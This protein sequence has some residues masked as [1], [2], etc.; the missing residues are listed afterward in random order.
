MAVKEVRFNSIL[1]G[2]SPSQ[3]VM[4]DGQYL[5]SLGIDPDLPLSS[6]DIR[7]SGAVVPS[8]YTKFSG[9][10]VNASVVAILTN[11]KNTNTYVVL[12]NGRLISYDSSLGS[13]TLIGTVSGGL[14]CGAWVYNNFLYLTTGT[15]V[16]R[17]GP[18]DSSPSLVDSWWTSTLSLTATT[19]TTYPTVQ[20]VSVPNHWGCIHG[21]GSAY[22][23]DFKNGQGM[24]HRINTK[25]GTYEG[26]TNGTTVPSAYNVLDLPFGFYPV[27]ISSYS[28]DLAILCI[29]TTDTTVNQGKAALFLWDPTNTDTFYRGP[30]Y[31]PDPLGTAMLYANGQ[32]NIWSGNAQ[33]G[34]RVS[35]Y[36][37]G[38]VVS[39]IAF[40]EEGTPPLAGAVDA[41]GSRLVWGGFATSPTTAACVYALG[42]KSLALPAGL[43]NVAK[44]TSAGTTPLVSAVKFVQQ[45]S[46]ISPKFVIGWHDGSGSGLDSFATSGTCGSK[47]R[48][49][50]NV[51]Q[52]FTVKTLRIPLGAA[53]TTNMSIV[54]KLL[55]DD[56]STTVTLDTI[57]P[58]GTFN[59][60]RYA[61]YKIGAASY[62]GTNDLVVELNFGGTVPLPV[63]LPI[64]VELDVKQDEPA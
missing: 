47:I 8:I 28:T 59:G 26:D 13:E 61:L 18:L 17:Y 16:S 15:D 2:I 12:S 41:F 46:N 1:G 56:A 38:D 40:Y 24:V 5:A 22:F 53:V 6:S 45:S 27:A 29:Q 11:P 32:L 54:P 51:G 19:N 20:G 7:T 52:S 4:Q 21:D 35:R 3:Y 57:D 37:G 64:I 33:N 63:L 49:F 58:N 42:S 39:D 31:L 23:L 55:F 36:V 14:C 30:V 60:K 62:G 9:S 34:F 44:S 48:F 25:K 43:H 50:V 10:N